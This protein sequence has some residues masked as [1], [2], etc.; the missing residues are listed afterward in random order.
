[1]N[2]ERAKLFVRL[3]LGPG[4]IIAGILHFTHAGSYL[5]VMPPYLPRP[6][7][8]VYLS[9]FLEILGGTG[10]LISRTRTLAGYGLVALL[11]AV[12][13]A[14]IH[15]AMQGVSLGGLPASPVLLW[16]RLPLQGVLIAA[17]WWST[18]AGQAPTT[19]YP[20]QDA[21]PTRPGRSAPPP[22]SPGANSGGE[23]NYV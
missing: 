1:M 15:M 11:V 23:R 7:E 3:M 14:N 22:P 9:G 21:R 16:L 4:F 6:L 2:R 10:L 20:P 19:D 5:R 13:P 17:V 12:F 8:L 18:R